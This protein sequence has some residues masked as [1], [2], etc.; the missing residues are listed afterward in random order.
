M[1]TTANM[2]G[3][4]PSPRRH[5][6]A[7]LLAFSKAHVHYDMNMFFEMA[8]VQSRLNRNNDFLE[9]L[10]MI[11]KGLTE[12]FA[13]HLRNLIVFFYNDDPRPQEVVAADFC[14]EGAWVHA[15]KVMTRTL[16]IAQKRADKS[17]LHLTM[18]R[19]RVEGPQNP[20]NFDELAIEI[21][22]IILVFVQTARPER[23]DPS[24]AL[25]AK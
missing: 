16:S 6:S 14:S 5:F 12:S 11:N 2:E 8:A 22:L 19:D 25:V 18:E 15:R 24:I 21:K 7:D 1:V 9:T 10:P 20:W 13:L 4:S 17:L 23:L 3:S